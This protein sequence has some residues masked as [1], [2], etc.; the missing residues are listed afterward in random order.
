MTKR[1]IISIIVTVALI[2]ASSI[3]AAAPFDKGTPYQQAVPNFL[4][5]VTNA[6]SGVKDPIE[7]NEINTW[8]QDSR[9]DLPEFLNDLLDIAKQLEA[10]GTPEFVF[11]KY[12][13]FA[14]K[15][16][17]ISQ[18][19]PGLNELDPIISP[20]IDQ[21]FAGLPTLQAPSSDNPLSGFYDLYQKMATENPWGFRNLFLLEP[22]PDTVSKLTINEL[23]KEKRTAGVRSK[24]IVSRDTLAT[25][26]GLVVFFERIRNDKNL[27]RFVRFRD[28]TM[29]HEIITRMKA[30]NED[31]N[32]IASLEDLAQLIDLHLRSAVSFGVLDACSYAY[33]YRKSLGNTLTKCVDIKGKVQS[34]PEFSRF[35]PWDDVNQLEITESQEVT[36]PLPNVGQLSLETPEILPAASDETKPILE[37][38]RQGFQAPAQTYMIGILFPA[39]LLSIIGFFKGI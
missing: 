20:I 4:D 31:P 22:L 32:V 27:Q 10:Q 11:E 25:V 14:D 24:S 19:Y 12:S 17:T 35:D 21:L 18:T 9:N 6:T 13:A 3:G 16:S 30:K 37:Q 28:P 34:V 23:L 8:A 2:G 38:Y 29:I 33:M 15:W 5:A 7:L 39:Y 36:E 1:V 26:N